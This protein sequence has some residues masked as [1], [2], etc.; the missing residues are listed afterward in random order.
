MP[1]PLGACQN[2]I[3]AGLISKFATNK[4]MF[5]DSSS[6]TSSPRSR[7]SPAMT[8][9][10]WMTPKST[11][12]SSFEQ[13]GTIRVPTGIVRT[14]KPASLNLT[15]SNG[16]TVASRDAPA[17]LEVVEPPP[18][19]ILKSKGATN[20]S[21]P[22]APAQVAPP[23][24]GAD[25][26]VATD[27]KPHNNPIENAYRLSTSEHQS[28]ST[29]DAQT[30]TE[31]QRIKNFV[32]RKPVGSTSSTASS[33]FSKENTHPRRST[34]PSKG[35][36]APPAQTYPS[37]SAAH[38]HSRETSQISNAAAFSPVSN[39]SLEE[40]PPLESQTSSTTTILAHR[41]ELARP[42]T[43]P[44]LR[45]PTPLSQLEESPSKY[46]MKKKSER[47]LKSVA[48]ER[49]SQIFGQSAN[50]VMRFLVSSAFLMSKALIMP[51]TSL[52]M[53]TSFNSLLAR[54]LC[55]LSPF[56]HC[57]QHGRCADSNL[58][59][60]HRE[61]SRTTSPKTHQCHQ[62]TTPIQSSRTKPSA[63]AYITSHCSI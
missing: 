17:V 20:K 36:R 9:A 56:I 6:V 57:G 16:S 33:A 26:A 7:H 27:V 39:R 44:V 30:T 18:A 63:P 55:S 35:S 41:S 15:K 31:M 29:T 8:E 53:S 52:K 12:K 43:P 1:V 34:S 48:E 14:S 54:L 24:V 62:Y 19:R 58:R 3:E 32:K 28:I 23:H 25:L 60:Q 59:R 46:G 13:E 22:P 10:Q 11:P 21:T 40:F 61:N 37:K 50:G 42:A 45:S 47:N 4:V 2:K 51:G 5:A 38:Q 49:Q